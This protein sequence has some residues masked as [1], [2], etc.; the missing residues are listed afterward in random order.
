MKK[1]LAILLFVFCFG[2]VLPE[3]PHIPVDNATAK[4]WHSDSFW[5]YPW[6]RSGVHKGIDIVAGE[7]TPVHASTR[8]FVLY[9]GSVDMGGNV[10]LMLGPRWRFHYFA[11]LKDSNNHRIGFVDAGEKIGAVGTS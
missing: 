10:V 6:G 11:H 2:F 1:T 9:S 4:D 7:G 5:Y 3:Q 8:G